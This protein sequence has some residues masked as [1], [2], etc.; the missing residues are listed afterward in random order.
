MGSGASVRLSVLQKERGVESASLRL[1]PLSLISSG[2]RGGFLLICLFIEQGSFNADALFEHVDSYSFLLSSWLAL[3]IHDCLSN[4]IGAH[5]TPLLKYM[6]S[7]Y[8][9]NRWR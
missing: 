7:C 9:T 8:V 6:I 4:V 2:W 5:M 1:M 3:G